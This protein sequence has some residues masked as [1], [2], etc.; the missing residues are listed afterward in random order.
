[1]LDRKVKRLE[2]LLANWFS[3][4]EQVIIVG[5]GNPI[6]RDDSVG[7]DVVKK[8]RGRIS[9]KIRLIECDSVPEN[10]LSEIIKLNP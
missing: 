4:R 9:K 10:Y 3:D 5:I 8:M 2:E 6:R 7:I 1:M